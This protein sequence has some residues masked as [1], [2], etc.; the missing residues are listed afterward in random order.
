M[1]SQIAANM[2]HAATAQTNT[3]WNIWRVIAALIGAIAMGFLVVY[4]IEHIGEHPHAPEHVPPMWQLG[5]LPFAALLGAIAILPLIPATHHWW[6]SNLNRLGVS[7]TCG[8]LTIVYYILAKGGD[9]ILP[10]LN[11]AIPVEY[12]P[13]IVLL[14]SL[15][16]ISGGINLK[17]DLAAHPLTNT[18]FLAFGAAIASFIGTTGASMLLIRPLLQTN[19]ERK[20]VVHTVVFF[21]FLVSNVGG[22]LLPI[23]DPPLFLGFLLGVDFFWTQNLAAP[24]ALCCV[25]LLVI[26]FGWDSFLYRR[27]DKKDIA[28]DEREKQPLRLKGV[29]NILWLAGVV[30]C[31]ATVSHEK[32]FFNTGFTPFP[33]MRE[34]LMLGFVGLSLL[35][36]PKGVREAN[37]F[38][39]A[40]I[41]EVAALFVGI[42]IAMQ[43]P[44]EVLNVMGGQLGLSEPWQF[45]WATGSLSSVLDNAPTYVVFF[46]TSRSMSPELYMNTVVRPDL[47]AG[48][49]L[50]AVFMG[51]MTYIGNGPN[52]M[53]KA[54]AEQSHVRMPSFFGY[55]FK[56]SLPVLVP[57]FIVIT[58]IFLRSGG[59]YAKMGEN[60][61]TIEKPVHVEEHAVPGHGEEPLT[62]IP[63]RRGHDAGAAPETH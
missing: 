33:F 43:V 14:F 19:A 8:G 31:V 57:V 27:E 48:V 3:N 44:I 52:F 13:F 10:V 11:H 37:H 58:F 20:H 5:V 59:M 24:W 49:S 39:Y 16:V 51:A 53:V 36:T 62:D 50:G 17:G 40:A 9:S 22:T 42:F 46:E 2:Q 35:T 55:V 54:I 38:N 15:Y 25:I 26:Y 47:L 34:L 63:G 32:E 30:A 45:F 12:I 29:I 28:R 21:I 7:L 23:G 6:E 1:A 56:Y 60:A 41:L 61:E 4:N 18:G